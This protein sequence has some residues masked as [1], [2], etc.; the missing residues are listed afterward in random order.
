[1]PSY[2]RDQ[3]PW[4]STIVPGE[5]WG[6]HVSVDNGTFYS[7]RVGWRRTAAGAARLADR[8]VRHEEYLRQ[9][10]NAKREVIRR[11]GEKR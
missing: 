7:Y 11:L 8:A 6:Y 9:K 2:E 5:R 10:R 3:R 1:M 4:R